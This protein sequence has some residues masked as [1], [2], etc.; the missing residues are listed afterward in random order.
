MTLDG[1]T[2]FSRNK[3]VRNTCKRLYYSQ[4]CWRDFFYVMAENWKNLK[5]LTAFFIVFFFFFFLCVLESK[6]I[7]SSA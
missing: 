7:G 5:V 2:S 1:V 6:W 4:N 3:N